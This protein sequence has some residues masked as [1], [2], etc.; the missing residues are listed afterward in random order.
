MP[1]SFE[2][3]SYTCIEKIASTVNTKTMLN[4]IETQQEMVAH[5]PKDGKNS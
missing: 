4:H 1:T 3:L 2:I 5:K